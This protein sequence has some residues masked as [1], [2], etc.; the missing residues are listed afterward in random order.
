MI[1]STQSNR[2]PW[3]VF[4]P[5][6]ACLLLL[7]SVV[8][9]GA[10]P[11]ENN[12]DIKYFNKYRPSADAENRGEIRQVCR[13]IT[14]NSVTY[15]NTAL[16]HIVLE[17]ENTFSIDQIPGS[18]VLQAAPTPEDVQNLSNNENVIAGFVIPDQ[19]GIRYA[20]R[21]EYSEDARPHYERF[22]KSFLEMYDGETL[23]WSVP[24]SE[25]RI[26]GF[27]AVSDGVIAHGERP[28]TS[29]PWM[30]KVDSTGQLQWRRLLDH[31]FTTEYICL[32]LENPDGSYAVISRGDYKYIC[33]SQY[34]ADGEET[35]FRK[36]LMGDYGVRDAAM[37][38][39]GYLV[40]LV[41]IENDE[42]RII[43]MEHD[44]NITKSFSYDGDA[45][46]YITDMI[47]YNG[48][49]YL[50]AYSVPKLA[51]E[52][53]NAGSRYEI[54]AVLNYLFDNEIWE[55]SGEELT[56]MV[57]DNYTA[58]LLVCDPATGIPEEFYAVDGS[59]GGE[60]SLSESGTLLWDVESITTT[61]FS[62]GTSSFTIGGISDVFRY[63]FDSSGV[64]VSQEKT[65]EIVPYRR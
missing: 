37:F 56:P 41:S 1:D 40:H 26:D 23:L 59:L 39:D 9:L 45:Y 19:D 47:D 5:F 20:Y 31:G 3:R 18:D 50:S 7:I 65:C 8:F 17:A 27:F 53:Q 33:L 2:R 25:F 63:A 38:E 15:K 29:L 42:F 14:T 55:I 58:M 21:T 22:E 62:P 36:T 13:E 16:P 28:K 44:G 43:K 12:D 61:F 52:D 35:S 24:I 54:A 4:I 10:P 34:T 51:D 64:L 49:I 46:Y 30:A 60:L 11:A 6:S 57:R 48:K 32:V